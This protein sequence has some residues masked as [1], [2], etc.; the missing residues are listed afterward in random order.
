LNPDRK[1]QQRPY[2]AFAWVTA[3]VILLVAWVQSQHGTAQTAGLMIGLPVIAIL[4]LI[5]IRF[6]RTIRRP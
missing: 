5:A 2:I 6:G 1:R 3:V 4:L